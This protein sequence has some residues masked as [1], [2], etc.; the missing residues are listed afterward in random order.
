M[1]N[2]HDESVGKKHVNVANKSCFIDGAVSLL[3]QELIQF[4]VCSSL[5]ILFL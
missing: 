5:V 2:I 4:K 3:F 1:Q